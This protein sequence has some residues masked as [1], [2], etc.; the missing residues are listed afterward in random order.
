MNERAGRLRD[1]AFSLLLSLA[2]LAPRLY[3]AIAWAREA[4]WDGHYYQVGAQRIAAGMGYSD[5]VSI[6]GAL[7][8]H[9]WCHFPVGYSGFLGGLFKVFGSGVHVATIANAVL[10][11]MLVFLTHRIALHMLSQTRARIAAVL[12]AI[13]PGLILY[14]ALVMTELLAA[15]LPLV[16]LLL[17][18]EL[19][20]KRR[21]LGAALSG[22][23]LG[24]ATLVSPP[25][26]V[27]SPALGAVLAGG[28]TVL[29]WN[30]WLRRIRPIL[31]LSATV[32]AVALA[33]VTPW[34]I[35]NCRVMDGC[36]F[37]STNGG[38]N[39]AIGAFPR[40]TGRFETLHASDGCEV[41][42][43]QV[44]QDRCWAKLGFDSI[45]NDPIRW[46]KLAPKKLDYC[47]NHESF[48]VGY[49]ATGDSP[50]WP[51][52]RKTWWREM[53]TIWHRLL[54]SVAVFGLVALP[55]RRWIQQRRWMPLA[56]ES[57]LML[58]LAALAFCAWTN[59]ATHPFWTLGVGIGVLGLWPRRS[60]PE[61]GVVGAFAG[62][63][64]ATFAM[65]H[66]VFFGE[67]RYHVPLVPLMCV[68]AA[69]VLRVAFRPEET[70]N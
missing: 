58:T 65:I 17:A 13:H 60:G 27:L 22:L 56:M 50:R 25:A 39:L 30:G 5:D 52:P 48:Q 44:Q 66:V 45:R 26:I 14:S 23:T 51:E 10:G 41:V 38:W 69:G 16:A 57:A 15:A 70:R 9:P 36:A 63:A 4:V 46:L 8:W 19:R 43:G 54:L 32:A 3:V 28:T 11:A 40:A 67:D 59:H 24:L 64:F 12:C 29:G 61:L 18:L 35:R 37:V 1:L 68:L 53:L 21:W 47:F 55:S 7:L 2:S 42:T 49:L 62:W 34:N 20:G 33:V 6:G 31:A